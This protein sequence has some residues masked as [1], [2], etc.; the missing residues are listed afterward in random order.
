M[1]REHYPV[2]HHDSHYA[3]PF[4]SDYDSFVHD[5][6]A[7]WMDRNLF[8]SDSTA[9][10]GGGIGGWVFYLPPATILSWEAGIF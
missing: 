2:P 4:P 10:F 3:Y 5:L 9:F 8:P 7:T 6:Q 1:G